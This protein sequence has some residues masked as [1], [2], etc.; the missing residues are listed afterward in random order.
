ME[1]PIFV[2]IT[3]GKF[4]VFL[5]ILPSTSSIPLQIPCPQPPPLFVF[6]LEQPNVREGTQNKLETFFATSYKSHILKVE[7]QNSR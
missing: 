7:S 4:T 1:I 2:F 3:P 6:F 5:E